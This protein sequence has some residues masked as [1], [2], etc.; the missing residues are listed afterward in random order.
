[1][2]LQ[3]TQQP[4]ELE[5]ALFQQ[6]LGEKDLLLITDRAL[7]LAFLSNPFSAQGVLRASDAAK[8]GN[9]IH[10]AWK[11]IDDKEWVELVVNTEKTGGGD[12]D[13]GDDGGDSESGSE[14]GSDAS[15]SA[16]EAEESGQ[17]APVA[18]EI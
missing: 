3:L 14:S 16:E 9:Q 17:G 18:M 6:T 8:V 10:S 2:L 12:S 5:A 7:P 11:V 15:Q 1:M 13:N 4:D